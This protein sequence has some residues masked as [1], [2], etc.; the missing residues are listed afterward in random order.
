MAPTGLNGHFRRP[1]GFA[2][3]FP[4]AAVFGLRRVGEDKKDISWGGENTLAFLR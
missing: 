1:D 4:A 3:L 2:A